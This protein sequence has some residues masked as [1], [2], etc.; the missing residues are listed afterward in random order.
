M[1][2]IAVD[3]I[4]PSTADINVAIKMA[5]VTSVTFVFLE[6]MLHPHSIRWPAPPT[7]KLGVNYPCHSVSRLPLTLYS[8]IKPLISSITKTNRC[9]SSS[10]QSGRQKEPLSR[11]I[12]DSFYSVLTDMFT[13]CNSAFN[14]STLSVCSQG[15]ST[16]V[17][18]K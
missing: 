1:V 9:V 4:V 3:T 6:P 18:P 15:R 12:N 13:Y 11:R 14:A 8:L 17:R 7:L 2:G 16:S 10:N 5:M